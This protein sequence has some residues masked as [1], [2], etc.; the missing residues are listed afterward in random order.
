MIIK[1]AILASATPL[2]GVT[3]RTF[4]AMGDHES[5]LL[6]YRLDPSHLAQNLMKSITTNEQNGKSTVTVPKTGKT[7]KA[8]QKTKAFDFIHVSD[9]AQAH[10]LA[11][12]LLTLKSTASDFK[13]SAFNLG[14]GQGGSAQELFM[15]FEIFNSVKITLQESSEVEDEKIGYLWADPIK[16]AEHLGWNQTKK[17]LAEMCKSAF[18]RAKTLRIEQTLASGEG[19]ECK[20]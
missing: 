2:R 6:H 20:G 17:T 18:A 7:G 11:L 4:D 12:E 10:L 9:V 16:S 3:L 15:T 13:H 5:G 1:D 19:V 8:W 14:S